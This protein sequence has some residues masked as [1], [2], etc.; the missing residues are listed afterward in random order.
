MEHV[1]RDV[2]A[3]R[4]CIC[5]PVGIGFAVLWPRRDCQCC[6][7]KV[8]EGAATHG[9]VLEALQDDG[10]HKPLKAVKAQARGRGALKRAIR[11]C[12]VLTRRKVG[13]GLMLHAEANES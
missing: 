1:V 6:R 12:G 4:V 2:H 7:P 13:G 11:E 10:R 8:V 5:I 3:S 9:D